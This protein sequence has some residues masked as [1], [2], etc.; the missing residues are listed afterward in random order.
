MNMTNWL[1]G[2]L[3]LSAVLLAGAALF[4]GGCNA[5]PKP[6]EAAWY[7]PDSYEHLGKRGDVVNKYVGAQ[8]PHP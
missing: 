1:H 5:K 7:Y 3:R 8:S 2:T 4:L 6:E